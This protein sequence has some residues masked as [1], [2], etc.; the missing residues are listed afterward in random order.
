MTCIDHGKSG[1]NEGF[2]PF[3]AMSLSESMK[4]FG[5]NIRNRSYD[6]IT[7]DVKKFQESLAQM[8]QI[9][10]DEIG[11]IVDRAIA[12]LQAV[13]MD[14][15][16]DERGKPKDLESYRAE[17]TKSLLKQKENTKL[18]SEQLEILSLCGPEVDVREYLRIG[19]TNVVEYAIQ[20]GFKI[21]G[22]DPVL[23][24]FEQDPPVKI[25]DEHPLRYAQMKEYKIKV[26][27]GKELTAEEFAQDKGIKIFPD[28]MKELE[29]IIKGMRGIKKPDNRKRRLLY[30]SKEPN[31]KRK[32]PEKYYAKA[33]LA[34]SGYR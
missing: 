23:S 12:D 9:Q 29:G 22:Q 31:K 27:G 10:D 32:G 13:G 25:E 7:F 4:G 20:K 21:D 3:F 14:K 8:A 30:K 5:N 24:A 15:F 34:G 1:T 33:I 6:S 2:D 26:E 18:L 16:H 19:N 11:N 17:L 28:L